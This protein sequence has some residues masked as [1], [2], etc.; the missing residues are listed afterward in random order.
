MKGL[1]AYTYQYLLISILVHILTYTYLYLPILTYTYL[2]TR[3]RRVELMPANDPDRDQI[4]ESDLERAYQMDNIYAAVTSVDV[5]NTTSEWSSTPQEESF[6]RQPRFIVPDDYPILSRTRSRS[7]SPVPE[8]N[9]FIDSDEE[10]VRVRRMNYNHLPPQ[11]HPS[12]TL[13]LPT[14]LPELRRGQVLVI[15]IKMTVQLVH[16]DDV[17]HI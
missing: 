1:H 16:P 4:T 10:E 13:M 12:L 8:R 2:D 3:P 17:A 7:T 11:Y 9:P 14:N 15:P 6:D 5:I